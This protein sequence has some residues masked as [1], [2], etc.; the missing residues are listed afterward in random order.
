MKRDTGAGDGQSDPHG[1]LPR[2]AKIS[3]IVAAVVTVLLVAAMLLGGGQHG[4][5]RHLGGL[6]VTVPALT[7]GA[8]AR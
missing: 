1:G 5:A 7:D 8:T 6:P 4:P 3:G 2:W